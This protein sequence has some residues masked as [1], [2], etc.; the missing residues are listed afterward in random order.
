MHLIRDFLSLIL[1]LSTF[2][3][4]AAVY[5][6]CVDVLF[7]E[8]FIA[9]T[10]EPLKIIT[11]KI[12]DKTEVPLDLADELWIHQ[13]LQSAHL[14]FVDSFPVPGDQIHIIVDPPD[15]ESSFNGI[16]FQLNLGQQDLTKRLFAVL[17]HEYGHLLFTYR[18]F[19]ESPE[20]NKTPYAVI[21]AVRTYNEVFA[22]L[23]AALF[24]GSGSCHYE[25][26]LNRNYPYTFDEVNSKER[27]AKLRNM[28]LMHSTV[29]I[30]DVHRYTYAMNTSRPQINSHLYFTQA[31]SYIWQA[32]TK[33]KEKFNSPA[34]FLNLVF[35][36]FQ[37]QITAKFSD[38][39]ALYS[40]PKTN[41]EQDNLL[42]IEAFNKALF[43]SVGL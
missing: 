20:L 33:H 31:R 10:A 14:V 24:C 41:I 28:N 43:S 1:I 2:E 15:G 5:K 40:A 3:L 12:K 16:N 42:L 29:E 27:F 39:A 21:D 30:Q 25:A 7:T 18:L 6:R 22:D 38:K 13:V 11:K 32:Y 19:L 4:N 34:E 9:S 8:V 36:V 17:L 26:I 35:K 37:K 23:T